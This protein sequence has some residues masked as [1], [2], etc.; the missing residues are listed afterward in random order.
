MRR[1]A[2]LLL[3]AASAAAACVRTSEMHEGARVEVYTLQQGGDLQRGPIKG[4][5]KL[6][7]GPAGSRGGEEEFLL[8]P[9]PR[10]VLCEVRLRDRT[11]LEFD[12]GQDGSGWRRLRVVSEDRLKSYQAILDLIRD[13]QP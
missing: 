5:L 3:L 6:V 7:T 9:L 2:P 4:V 13:S 11:V 1:C 12:L 8:L 10:L